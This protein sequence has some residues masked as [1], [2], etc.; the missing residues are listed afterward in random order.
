[1]PNATPTSTPGAIK[2]STGSQSPKLA[3]AFTSRHHQPHSRPIGMDRRSLASAAS[4]TPPPSSY[5]ARRFQCTATDVRRLE[6]AVGNCVGTGDHCV[7]CNRIA[8]FLRVDR[9]DSAFGYRPHASASTDALLGMLVSFS[10]QL[11]RG[12]LPCDTAHKQ[13]ASVIATFLQQGQANYLNDAT[14]RNGY[15]ISLLRTRK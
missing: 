15:I 1:M 13:L 9:K 6:T 14:M 11:E 3:I 5:S 8:T 2:P 10:D 12:E 4:S 7:G